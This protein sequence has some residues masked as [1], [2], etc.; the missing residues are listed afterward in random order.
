MVTYYVVQ[1][2]ERTKRGAIVADTPIEVQ[3]DDAARRLV[4]RLSST[5]AGAIA[6]SRTGDP[7]TGEFDDAVVLAAFGVR[8]SEDELELAMAG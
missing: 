3:S 2:F 1:S 5:K 7:S 6:F 8:L 4:D